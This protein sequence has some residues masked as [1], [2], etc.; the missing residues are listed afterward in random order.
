MRK[1]KKPALIFLKKNALYY[2]QAGLKTPLQIS[3]PEGAAQDMEVV[4]ENALEENLKQF[5]EDK[6]ILPQRLLVILSPEVIFSKT[7]KITKSD[8]ETIKQ[9]FLDTIPFENVGWRSYQQNTEAIL[10]A[11]NKNFYETFQQIFERLGFRVEGIIPQIVLPDKLDNINILKMIN[12]ITPLSLTLK[13]QREDQKIRQ[14]ATRQFSAN[15]NLR[16][17]LPVF[18]ISL[19]ILAATA[20]F[21]KSQQGKAQTTTPVQPTPAPQE[22]IS[23][24]PSQL[25]IQI[26]YT[27]AS[28]AQANS[29]KNALW[30]AGFKDTNSQA[31]DSEAT[32]SAKTV[33][34]F[35]SG[36]PQDLVKKLILEVDKLNVQYSIQENDTLTDDMVT[37]TLASQK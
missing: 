26:F 21:L 12:T 14:I 6:K 16:I 7:I 28:Q 22:Q 5:I 24:D 2:Y 15:R 9:N 29:L 4:D 19:L 36:V 11:A 10:V 35:A 34:S 17:L 30:T 3:L 31:I 1:A 37:I 27:T 33:I 8:L 20:I 32:T 23:N 25:K 18:L 13:T